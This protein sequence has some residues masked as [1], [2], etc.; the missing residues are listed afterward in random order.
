M[1]YT[2]RLDQNKA[3]ELAR[4]GASLLLLNVPEG[5]RIGIDHQNFMAGP[6]FQ[7]V[8]MLPPGA[9]MV[10]YNAA[11][12]GQLRQQDFGPT[13]AFF[14]HLAS[15]QVEVRRWDAQ[16]E[17]LVEL[18]EDEAERYAAGVKRFDFDAGLGPYDLHRFAQWQRLAGFISDDVIRRL[19]PLPHGNMS[20]T[21]EGDPSLL[22]PATAAEERLYQQLREGREAGAADLP[23]RDHVG[24]A[25]YTE[26]PRVVKVPGVTGAQLS[27]LNLDKSMLLE[28]VL[29]KQYHRDSRQLLGELQFA[30]LAFLRG[31]SLEG[32]AQWK[33]LVQL[34]LSCEQAPLTTQQGL[35][36]KFLNAL[37]SQLEVSLQEEPEAGSSSM[38]AAFPLVEEMLA[39]SFLHQAF[40]RFFEGLQDQATSAM[41]PGLA[42]ASQQLQA[43]LQRRLGWDFAVQDLGHPDSDDEYAPVVVALNEVA[44]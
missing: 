7:G 10:S 19:Q 30:F 22:Q 38:P 42:K 11:G 39:D 21:A 3:K 41:P 15:G 36:V 12:Q 17:L 2:V 34:L 35:F 26:L 16:H 13:T 31:Q 33:A 28:Q 24:R 40:Q 32:F 8:K 27:A 1:A 23:A 18:E 6:K 4:T 20:I 43:C 5:T 37:Q 14:L 29:Q 9:H 25:R 44:L